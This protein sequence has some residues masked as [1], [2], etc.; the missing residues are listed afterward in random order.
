[1]RIWLLVHTGLWLLMIAPASW[2]GC[3]WAL[4]GVVAPLE[5]MPWWQRVV[6]ASIFALGLVYATGFMIDPWFTP[7]G[8]A[9][10]MVFYYLGVLL[11]VIGQGLWWLLPKMVWPFVASQ[12]LIG[13]LILRKWMHSK[14]FSVQ[15]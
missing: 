9:C 7:A 13:V 15:P 10:A 1:M 4:A 5:K 8:T 2:L 6:A 12:I 14:P 11:W 3:L